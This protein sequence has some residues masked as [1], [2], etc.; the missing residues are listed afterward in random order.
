M[1]AA[2]IG[3]RCITARL[4]ATQACR[5]CARIAA[6]SCARMAVRANACRAESST[7]RRTLRVA[8]GQLC[9]PGERHEA[10]VSDL[11]GE[12][13][14]IRWLRAL[15]FGERFWEQPISRLDAERKSEK[16]QRARNTRA[17]RGSLCDPWPRNAIPYTPQGSLETLGANELHLIP[18]HFGV[19]RERLY[20]PDDSP[21]PFSPPFRPL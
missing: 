8:V 4:D 16:T 14:V 12:I 2:H 5:Y 17:P 10:R 3:A 13:R 21:L 18:R 11:C 7:V 1:V 9:A 6:Q 19:P 15:L 20:L